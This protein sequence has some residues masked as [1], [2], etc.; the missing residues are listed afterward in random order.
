MKKIGIHIIF[1]ATTSDILN[2]ALFS[3]AL[4]E[5]T[6]NLEKDILTSQDLKLNS[7]FS[8]PTSLLLRRQ[9]EAPGT[10]EFEGRCK[11]NHQPSISS[12]FTLISVL[13]TGEPCLRAYMKVCES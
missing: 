6:R 12:S 5:D 1:V 2:V 3:T 9:E 11:A 10:D 4:Q 8:F 7:C 13:H